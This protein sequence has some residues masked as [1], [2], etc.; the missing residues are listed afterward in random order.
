M[1]IRDESKIRIQWYAELATRGKKMSK[2]E[3]QNRRSDKV[4]INSEISH[5]LNSVPEVRK[6][7]V[8]EARENIIAGKYKDSRVMDEIVDR[9]IE[10]FGL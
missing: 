10:Q 7:K 3:G 4:Q 1:E 9:L 8:E 5:K 2:K 6:D